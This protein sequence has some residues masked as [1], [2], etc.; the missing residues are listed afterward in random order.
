MSNTDNHSG[1]ASRLDN[2]DNIGNYIYQTINLEAN[3]QYTVSVYANAHSA[4]YDDAVQAH[5]FRFA[6]RPPG[7]S[8]TF[9]D[10]NTMPTYVDEWTFQRYSYTFKTTTAGGYRVGIAPPYA[11]N[12]GGYFGELS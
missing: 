1:A 10:F 4:L 11:G 12:Q 8:D 5:Q 7:G 2:N 9:S 3:T 6:Y